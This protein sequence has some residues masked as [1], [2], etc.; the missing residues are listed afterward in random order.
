MECVVDSATLRCVRCGA[1]VSGPAVRR[2]CEGVALGLLSGGGPGT[3]L[4]KLLK[5]FGIEPTPTCACRAKAAEMDAWGCDEASKP[6]RIDEVVA[7][8]RT[9][10][11]TRGF[12]FIDAVGRMLV[13]R[14][15]SNAR[16]AAPPPPET[17]SPSAQ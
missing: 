3:E 9:E 12:P 1:A 2:N 7:V 10:A 16:R 13:K 6:E 4:S 5:K 14:A 8:M 15:I 17:P 11:Q